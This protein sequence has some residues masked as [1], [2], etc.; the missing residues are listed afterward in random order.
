LGWGH[1]EIIEQ[2][3]SQVLAHRVTWDDASL[4]GLHN[5]G[6]DAVTVSFEQADLD[7]KCQLVDLL[8]TGSTTPDKTGQTE[9]QL[10]GYGYRWLRVTRPGDRRLR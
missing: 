3:H 2:P 7:Q 9:L 6:P 4:I 10:D 5:L 1:L 8:Q